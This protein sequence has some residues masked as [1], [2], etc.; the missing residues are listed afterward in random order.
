MVVLNV[1]LAHFG[2]T[3]EPRPFDI[4]PETSATQ[5]NGQLLDYLGPS[6]QGSS[7]RIVYKGRILND[8][9]TIWSTNVTP[10]DYVVVVVRP[11]V[12]SAPPTSPTAAQAVPP[13]LPDP[14][15]SHLPTP[16]TTT[17]SSDPICVATAGCGGHSQLQ[18]SA[19]LETDIQALMN[20][21]HS[22]PGCESA[23]RA[24]FGDHDLARDYL[25]TTV[26]CRLHNSVPSLWSLRRA[27]RTWSTFLKKTT[28]QLARR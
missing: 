22:S 25:E 23:L 27:S 15:T 2:A 16:P 21:G 3:Q 12:N 14:S 26:G 11:E 20:R 13:P 8:S 7:L 9:A 6:S 4:A 28:R 19:E 17:P 18:H 1:K 5:L 24:T 10:R